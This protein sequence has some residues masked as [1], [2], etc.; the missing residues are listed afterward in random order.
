MYETEIVLTNCP[1]QIVINIAMQSVFNE[2]YFHYNAFLNI[3][4]GKKLA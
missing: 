4:H 2:L 1:M 3:F